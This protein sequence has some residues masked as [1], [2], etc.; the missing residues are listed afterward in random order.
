MADHSILHVSQSYLASRVTLETCAMWWLP[1]FGRA[2]SFAAAQQFHYDMDRWKWLNWFLYLTDVDAGTAPHTIIQRSHQRLAKPGPILA[3]GY[4]RMDDAELGQHYPQGDFLELTGKAGTLMAVDTRVWHK[5]KIP[6]TG[7]RLILE[8]VCC[9]S[10]F[11]NDSLRRGPKL[12]SRPIPELARLA[13]AYPR[14]YAQY[15]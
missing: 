4:V 14:L 8:I 9:T 13:D 10:M 5:A 11:G 7:E 6:T 2:P 3:R 15:L 12:P 1:V